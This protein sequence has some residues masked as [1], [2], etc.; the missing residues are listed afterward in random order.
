MAHVPLGEPGA[1]V[2]RTSGKIL[3]AFQ[4]CN[5]LEHFTNQDKL[6]DR[7]P[8]KWCPENTSESRGV[9]WSLSQCT[10]TISEP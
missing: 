10:A 8:D 5:T 6:F 9:F 3:K 2:T 1:I 4:N 7:C